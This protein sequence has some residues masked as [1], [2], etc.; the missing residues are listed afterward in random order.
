[1]HFNCTNFNGTVLLQSLSTSRMLY[2]FAANLNMKTISIFLPTPD[3][4][5]NQVSSNGVHGNALKFL[6]FS[7]FCYGRRT[8]RTVL[9]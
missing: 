9:G 8:L 2:K 5:F 4:A 1:M 7:D 3:A 6:N